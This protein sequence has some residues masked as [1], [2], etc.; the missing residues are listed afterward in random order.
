MTRLLH[1]ESSPRK[2]R[3]ASREVAHAF[4][5]A[6]R[7]AHADASVETL[8]LWHTPLPEFDGAAMQAK[9]AGLAGTPL[10]DEQRDAWRAIHDLARP[11]HDAHTL[12]LSVPLW[13]FSIPYKLKHFIDAV[14][15]KDVLFSFDE[16]GFGGLLRD[17]R[18]VVVY[19]RGL[20]YSRESITPAECFDFQK[21]YVEAWL[22]FVGIEDIETVVIEKTLFGPEVDI[23]ARRDACASAEALARARP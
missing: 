5:E 19:A 9:Y 8:D 10:T 4:I 13:N 2:S 7:S 21:P 14:S 3:S 15:Q 16:R 17:K 12:L 6:Y 23:A 20:D 22:R 1:I 18:A 11:L